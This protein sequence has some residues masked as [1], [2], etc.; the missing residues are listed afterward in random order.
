MTSGTQSWI[1]RSTGEGVCGVLRPGSL[2]L[3][4]ESEVIVEDPKF[5]YVQ[6]SVN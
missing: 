4:S 6:M 5:W 2:G 1:L 3:M